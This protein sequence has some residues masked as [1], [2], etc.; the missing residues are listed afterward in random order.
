[1]CITMLAEFI[2][3]LN[4]RGVTLI[5]GYVLDWLRAT[6]SRSGT[7]REGGEDHIY[8]SLEQAIEDSWVMKW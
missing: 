1:M 3:K 6:L 5:L 4:A 2:V 7:A 8:H